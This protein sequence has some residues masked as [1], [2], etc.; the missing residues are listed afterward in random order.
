MQMLVIE[1]AKWTS[2]SIARV[3]AENDQFRSKANAAHSAWDRV[4]RF[5]RN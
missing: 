5:W 2:A 3:F 1:E 4:G